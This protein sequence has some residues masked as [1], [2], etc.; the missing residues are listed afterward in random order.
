MQ[1]QRPKSPPNSPNTEPAG[2]GEEL[3]GFYINYCTK[4]SSPIPNKWN[5]ICFEVFRV[6]FRKELVL[7]MTPT[8]FGIGLVALSNK[9]PSESIFI[10]GIV[11]KMS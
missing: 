2:E 1:Y 8:G 10:S 5:C 6:S 11:L 9:H 3:K 4:V 7:K